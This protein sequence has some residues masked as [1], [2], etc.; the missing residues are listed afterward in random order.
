M[1]GTSLA[2]QLADLAVVPVGPRRRARTQGPGPGV[3][4][5]PQTAVGPA[6]AGGRNTAD[7]GPPSRSPPPVGRGGQVVGA[8]LRGTR[9]SRVSSRGFRG[10]RPRLERPGILGGRPGA[11]LMSS[12]WLPPAGHLWKTGMGPVEGR[13]PPRSLEGSWAGVTSSDGTAPVP[14]IGFSLISEAAP[15]CR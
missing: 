3:S 8:G 5:F 10:T 12:G 13:R 6:S 15:S 11:F 7:A 4:A 9:S 14:V 1:G 2:A